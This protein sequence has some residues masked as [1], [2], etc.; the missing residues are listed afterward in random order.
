MVK[1]TE[2]ILYD[3]EVSHPEYGKLYVSAI[4]ADSATVVAAKK[5]GISWVE[6]ARYCTIQNRGKVT[7]PLCLRCGKNS[8]MSGLCRRCYNQDI[9]IQRTRE[10]SRLKTPVRRYPW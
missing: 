8:V 9:D 2:P 5:W 1:K 10:L 3:F 6:N 4:A 7:P